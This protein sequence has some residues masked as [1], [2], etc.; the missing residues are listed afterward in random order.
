MGGS[1]QP[2]SGALPIA[3]F[4]GDV[5]SKEFLFDDKNTVRASFSVK[6]SWFQKLRKEA[7]TRGRIPVI[8]VKFDST[9]NAYYL[10]QEQD[11]LRFKNLLQQ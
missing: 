8:R 9:G 5:I 3:K 6:E 7:M 2:A 1:V 11:F 4:K 10:L